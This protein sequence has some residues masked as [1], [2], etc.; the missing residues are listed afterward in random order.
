MSP[1]LPVLA[2]APSRLRCLHRLATSGIPRSDAE[3]FPPST[4]RQLPE[5]RR[6]TG[7][8]ALFEGTAVVKQP[9]GLAALMLPR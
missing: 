9:R 5:F 6:V 3:D 4:R 1:Q 8:I 7:T 2:P